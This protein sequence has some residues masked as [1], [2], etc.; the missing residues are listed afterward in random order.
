MQ[1]GIAEKHLKIVTPALCAHQLQLQHCLPQLRN[2]DFNPLQA[3][4]LHPFV[5]I[6]PS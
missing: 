4:R 1:F 3:K 5:L 2:T 6:I